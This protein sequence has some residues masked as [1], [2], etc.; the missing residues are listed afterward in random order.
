MHPMVHIG[1][2]LIIKSEGFF[3]SALQWS[4]EVVQELG[5]PFSAVFREI[6]VNSILLLQFLDQ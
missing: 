3:Q 5:K 1:F 4:T 2:R 6:V